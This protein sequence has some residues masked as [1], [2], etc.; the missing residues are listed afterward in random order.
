MARVA[1]KDVMLELMNTVERLDRGFATHAGRLDEMAKVAM[2]MAARTAAL[3]SRSDQFT[4]RMNEM[5]VTVNQLTAN[6][7]SMG[8]EVTRFTTEVGELSDDTTR[9][10][11]I[12]I[13]AARES[14]ETRGDLRRLT[15]LVGALAERH[16][17]RLDDIEARVTRL[18]KKS[19]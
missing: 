18:E 13:T 12:A 7:S 1:G 4:T 14:Q 19:A 11:E 15:R 5:T 16:G 9:F 17:T 10:A 6:V 8:A 3:A 2:E